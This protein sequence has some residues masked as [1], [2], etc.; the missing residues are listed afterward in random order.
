MIRV[1]VGGWVYPEWR[2]AFYPPGLPH[3]R[4]LEY[5]SH[6]L[7]TIEINGTFY[8]TQSPAS[9]RR[10]HDETPGNFVFSLKGPRFATHRPDLADAGP[11]IDRFLA[12]GVLELRDKLGPILWQFPGMPSDEGAFGAFLELL[13]SQIDGR[14]LRH[15]VE[16]RGRKGTPGAVIDLLRRNRAALVAGDDRP[17][18]ETADFIY[19]HLRRCAEEE[20]AGYP[21]EA[22]DGWAA[23]LRERAAQTACDCFVYFISGA[24]IRA[25]AAALALLERLGLR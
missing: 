6:R 20:P 8:R 11:V 4:E 9:F 5:A 23:R 3:A 15:A 14:V 21:P 19:A 18:L 2:G 1:G 13:P 10:W 7:T 17:D 24:K 22:L 25:P 12:S 16:L